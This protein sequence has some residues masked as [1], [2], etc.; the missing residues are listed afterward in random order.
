MRGI[1]LTGLA[2]VIFLSSGALGNRVDAMPLTMPSVV[3]AA[4]AEAPLI[5]RAHAVCGSNGCVQVH[6]AGPKKPPTHP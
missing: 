1:L 3:G 5:Q 2:T 4:T 6:V